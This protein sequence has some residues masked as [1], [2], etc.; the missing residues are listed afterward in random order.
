MRTIRN[1]N[2]G[3]G[4]A[5][6]RNGARLSDTSGKWHLA[7]RCG[8][9]GCSKD[10]ATSRVILL[11]WRGVRSDRS[12]GCSWPGIH[13]TGHVDEK[14]SLT[15]C[16]S[17]CCS[18]APFLLTAWLPHSFFPNCSHAWNQFFDVRGPFRTPN[19]QTSQKKWSVRELVTLLGFF[20]VCSKNVQQFI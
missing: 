11:L 9:R 1:K 12:G 19:P 3:G 10:E 7:F 4:Q 2:D 8:E 14:W 15:R 20:W 5:F 18:L 13:M 16:S 17:R 6:N